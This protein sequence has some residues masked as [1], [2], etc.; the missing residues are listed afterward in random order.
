MIITIMHISFPRCSLPLSLYMIYVYSP[1]HPIMQNYVSVD[2]SLKRLE[3][4]MNI[5][6]DPKKT[7]RD[8]VISAALY[9]S[10][11]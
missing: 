4:P 7:P 5:G 1:L 3:W 8:Q 6:H 11:T 2:V 9:P 10:S